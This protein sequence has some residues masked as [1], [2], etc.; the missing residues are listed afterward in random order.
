MLDIVSAS[1]SSSSS[2]SSADSSDNDASA[3][4]KAAA[5]MSTKL[6]YTLARAMNRPQCQDIIEEV[7]DSFVELKGDG[8]VGSDACIRG[9]FATLCE[10]VGCVV[11]G[12]YKGHTP[13]TMAESN[14]GMASPHGYRKALRLMKLRR[15]LAC[16]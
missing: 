11:I 6:D 12:S 7:F 14:Y 16:Q 4:A 15:G 10:G 5:G 9:G 8:R 3:A 13:A 1:S 2:L